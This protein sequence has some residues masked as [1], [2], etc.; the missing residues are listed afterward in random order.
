MTR[1][2]APEH[3]SGKSSGKELTGRHVLAITLAAFAVII[4]VNLL[5]AFK[6]VST[7]PGLEVQ[8]SYVASQSFD[9]D[10][11]AQQA[12]GWTVTPEY[13]GQVLSLA[14]R[15]AQGYPAR[16]QSLEVTI[17]RPTHIRDD[18]KLDLSYQGG[19]FSAP[20]ALGPGAWVIHLQAMSPDGT[21][22]RQ[23]IDHI[24]GAGEQQP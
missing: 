10:R 19:L 21:P 8:N 16:I 6:A 15:D 2:L 14:I 13:D 17:G 9:R 1:E 20:V 4:G 11:A 24:A 23:R 5:M 3:S 22:F 12:L 18:R 7:F